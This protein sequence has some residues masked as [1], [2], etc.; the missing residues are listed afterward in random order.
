MLDPI[1]SKLVSVIIPLCNKSNTIL[2]TL[3]GVVSQSHRE[4]EIVVVDDGSDDNGASLIVGYE[5]PRV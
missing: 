2:K 5:D 1:N 4:L 3:A